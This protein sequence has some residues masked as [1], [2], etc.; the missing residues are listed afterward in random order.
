MD[1]SNMDHH[2]EFTAES[3][4]AIADVEV[5]DLNTRKSQ[6]SLSKEAWAASQSHL[7][8]W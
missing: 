8:S 7:G 2:N 4:Y 1:S 5:T 6:S 3:K